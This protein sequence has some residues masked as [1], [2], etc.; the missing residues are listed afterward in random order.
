[1]KKLLAILLAFTLLGVIAVGCA[2]E[3]D[4]EPVEEIEEIQEYEEEAVEEYEEEEEPEE[5]QQFRIAISLPPILNDFHETMVEEFEKAISEAPENFEFIFYYGG[6]EPDSVTQEYALEQI[7]LGEYDGVIISPWY[8]GAVGPLA[9]K[10]YDT[11]IPVIIVN[12][13]ISP[14]VYTTFVAGDN[15]GGARL[16]AEYI[17]EAVADLEEVNVFVLRMIVDTP[18]DEDRQEA[19][20]ILESFP[21]ITIIG[22]AERAINFD[23][24]YEATVAALREHEHI[25]VIY[26]HGEFAARGAIQAFKDADRYEELILAT[27]FGGARLLLEEFEENPDWKLR[28][29]AY[30]PGM[31]ATAIT[32]MID[33]LNGEEVQRYVIDPP[34][35]LG[36]ENMSEWAHMVF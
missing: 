27:G 34:L 12:R 10:I 9:E 25:D 3:P 16:M 5:I 28:V 17:G 21:N 20:E 14:E 22:E 33:I 19:I 4:P 31:G 7:M 30:L 13:M 32:T 23:T 1:M 24:G 36:P 18:I 15:P 35:I 26:A 6:D 29:A 11:G 2:D 8:G